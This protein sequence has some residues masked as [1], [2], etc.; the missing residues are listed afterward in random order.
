MKPHTPPLILYF[1]ASFLCVLFYSLNL[2][3]WV[4]YPKA[5]VLPSIFYYYYINNNHKITVDK[6]AVFILSFIAD[7]Y[8]LMGFDSSF[9]VA[10]C[11]VVMV[12]LIIIRYVIKDFVTSKLRKKDA[13]PIA[14]ALIFITYLLVTMMTLDFMN[15]RRFFFLFL[16]HGVVLAVMGKLAIVNYIA[17]G[18][19]QTI[20]SVLMWTC[21]ALSDIFYMLYHFYLPIYIFELINISAQVLCYFFIVRYFLRTDHMVNS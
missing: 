1:I 16:F 2:D 12:Y 18:S 4:I 8:I 14:V 11:C 15:E 21:F 5:A 6:A 10:E 19:R 9:I 20:S 17:K 7:M 3:N 13:I